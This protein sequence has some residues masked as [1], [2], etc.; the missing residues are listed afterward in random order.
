MCRRTPRQSGDKENVE[1]T[2]KKKT[3]QKKPHKN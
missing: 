2:G 3:E 1:V